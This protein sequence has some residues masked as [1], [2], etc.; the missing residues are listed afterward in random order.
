MYQDD[1]INKIEKNF[2]ELTK[3]M[4]E[5]AMPA[6]SGGHIK[7]PDENEP[8]INHE[9]KK[10]Y[11][12]GIGMLLYLVKFSRPDI[13]NAVRELSKFMD[14][15]TPAHMKNML[16]PIKFVIDTRQR[17]LNFDLKEQ[18]GSQWTLKAF[19]DSDWAG[20]KDDR[21]SIKG[22]CVYLNGFHPQHAL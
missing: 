1:L 5:Y 21:R 20:A 15:A 6:G 18:E 10:K 9:D 12:S 2:G 14:G 3:N 16:R 8:K 19:S 13:S 11:R 7:R 17:V 22:Y 4:Q